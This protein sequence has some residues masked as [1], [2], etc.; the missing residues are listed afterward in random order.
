VTG[1]ADGTMN[2]GWAWLLLIGAG[3]LE[4]VWAVALKQADGLTRFWP[5]VIGV[6]AMLASGVVLTLTLRALPVGTA[7]AIWVGIGA[8]GVAVAGM[9]AFDESTSLAR[10]MCLALILSGVV[11]LRWLET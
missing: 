6:T 4:I 10:I 7:Y 11:G 5:S 8:V 2:V 1:P 3:L 9:L